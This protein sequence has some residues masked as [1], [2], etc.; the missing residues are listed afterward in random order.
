[1]VISVILFSWICLLYY[2]QINT[3]TYFNMFSLT[4]INQIHNI[5]IPTKCASMFMMYFIHNFLTN[6]SW[7]LFWP[8]TGWCYTL[9]HGFHPQSEFFTQPA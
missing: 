8:P 6:M 1:V 5:Q 4:C 9:C 2:E 3:K 7:P